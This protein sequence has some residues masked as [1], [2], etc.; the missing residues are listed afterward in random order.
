MKPTSNSL[1]THLADKAD[2][3]SKTRRKWDHLDRIKQ[4]QTTAGLHAYK[5]SQTV[6]VAEYI[7]VLPKC[8]HFIIL[9]FKTIV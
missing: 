8:Q 7:N 6:Q 3:D 1:Y 5:H 4:A 9:S 2:Y